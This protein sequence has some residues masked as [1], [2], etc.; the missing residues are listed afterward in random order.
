MRTVVDGPRRVEFVFETMIDDPE[1]LPALL[2]AAVP[3]LARFADSFFERMYLPDRGD[4]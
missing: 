2:E 3:A 4:A 1:G